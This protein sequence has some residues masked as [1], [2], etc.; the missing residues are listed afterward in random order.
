MESWRT[1]LTCLEDRTVREKKEETEEGT[2]REEEK[3]SLEAPGWGGWSWQGSWGLFLPSCLLGDPSWVQPIPLCP[4]LASS[5]PL[6]SAKP[7]SG[8]PGSCVEAWGV[9]LPTEGC[10]GCPG[11]WHQT[12]HQWWGGGG[13]AVPSINISFPGWGRGFRIWSTLSALTVEGLT[14]APSIP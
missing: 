12:C 1:Q 6:R 7:F 5:S 2:G 3:L 13:G 10:V 8:L 4:Q 14:F 11:C 9:K